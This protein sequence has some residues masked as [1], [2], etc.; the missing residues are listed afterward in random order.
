MLSIPT[1][2]LPDNYANEN[3]QGGGSKL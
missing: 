2:R 1:H 3:P